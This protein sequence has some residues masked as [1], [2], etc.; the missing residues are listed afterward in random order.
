[1][2]RPTLNDRHVNGYLGNVLSVW[3]QD[4]KSYIAE[5]V[6]PTVP[7]DNKTDYI[8]QYTRADWLRD[9]AK[10]RAPGTES[11]GGGLGVEEPVEYNCKVF[12][13]HY[14]LDDQIA[15]NTSTP[16]N[17]QRDGT[18]IVGQKLL[19]RKERNFS[20]SFWGAGR[21]WNDMAGAAQANATHFVYLNTAGEDPLKTLSGLINAQG[22]KTG[23]RPNVVVMGPD[24]WE[25]VKNHSLVLDRIKHTQKG[26]WTRALMAEA[27][28]IDKFLVPGAVYN[29]AK[30]GG[31]ENIQYIMKTGVLICYTPK[32]VSLTKPCSGLTLGW[33]GYQGASP[34]GTRVKKF[35][36]DAINS[37]RI[38]GDIAIAQKMVCGALGMYLASPLATA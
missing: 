19:I 12:S 23:F 9:D 34:F 29:S 18:Q 3:I 8:A 15:G 16:F 32:E 33:K 24:V 21:G 22:E 17:A 14:D 30:R 35:R 2:P 38:E 28:E 20:T 6:F 37:D 27:L 11:A 10:E 25:E 1:M 26:I 31:A 13:W 36:M 4:Q 7:V 5:D